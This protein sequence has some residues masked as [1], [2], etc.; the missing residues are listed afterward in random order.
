MNLNTLALKSDPAV[1][2]A[3][4]RAAKM[5][6]SPEQRF[7]QRVSFVFGSLGKNNTMTKDQV[8]QQ[9]RREMGD[10]LAAAN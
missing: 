9:L 3:L 4:E 6:Q 7:E 2:Q 10:L 1:L 5:S 8:R